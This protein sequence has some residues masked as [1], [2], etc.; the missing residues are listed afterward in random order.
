[1]PS[2]IT[3]NNGEE[4]PISPPFLGINKCNDYVGHHMLLTNGGRE[5][6]R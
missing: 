2:L 5:V 6:V 1:M 3:G 4:G